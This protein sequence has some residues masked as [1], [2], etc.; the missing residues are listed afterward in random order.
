MWITCKCGPTA[1]TLTSGL[2]EAKLCLLV[3]IGVRADSRKELI[4]L[5]DGYRAASES[6]ADL[7]R[8]C[9]RRGTRGP[10]LAIADEPG[11]RPPEKS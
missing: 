11:R 1:S 6:W 2:E 3:L 8:D 10:V 7:L 9:K 4:A 5:D